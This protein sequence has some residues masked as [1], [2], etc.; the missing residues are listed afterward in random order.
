[1]KQLLLLV[2]LFSTNLKAQERFIGL[3]KD[4]I[5]ECLTINPFFQPNLCNY[6]MLQ[7]NFNAN[8]TPMDGQLVFYFNNDTCTSIISNY[9]LQSDKTREA[10]HNEYNILCSLNS[11]RMYFEMNKDNVL[12]YPKLDDYSFVNIITNKIQ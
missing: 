1:M 6:N 9:P 2:L 5:L 12:K 8:Y 10:L 7:T 11:K 3:E 4:I